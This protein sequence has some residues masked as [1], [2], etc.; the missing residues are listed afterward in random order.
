MEEW[1]FGAVTNGDMLAAM[2]PA[3]R[4]SFDPAGA[5]VLLASA[6]ALAI[7]IGALIGWA[8]GSLGL[9]VVV[10]AVVGIPAGVA[11]VYFRYREALS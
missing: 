10:G 7:G 9:G 2:E 11:A 5:G 8:L 4:P 6:T 1:R 3:A